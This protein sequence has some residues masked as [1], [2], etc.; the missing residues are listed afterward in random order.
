[1][2]SMYTTVPIQLSGQSYTSR[3][4][5]ISAQRSLNMYPEI[6]QDGIAPIIMHSWMGMQLANT[7]FDSCCVSG[8]YVFLGS[9]YAVAGGQLRK[10]SPDLASY[11][12]VGSVPVSDGNQVSFSDNGEVMLIATGAD[13]YQSDGVTV[14]V[15]ASALFNP[16]KV[17]FLNER[18]YINGD[19]G[20][21]AVSDVLSTN[22]D[23]GN[24]FYGRS[25]PQK[26][27]VHHIFNQIIYLFDENSV[28]PWQP[29]D[30]GAPP[31]A[32]INQGII[33]GVGCTSPYGV[34]SSDRYMYFIGA[35]A[36]VYRVSG[37]SAEEITNPVIAHHF[38][39]MD[40][41]E[42][43]VNYIDM[44]GHKFII[45]NFKANREVWVYCE[46]SS[47]WFEIG[48]ADGEYEPVSPVFYRGQWYAGSSSNG[49]ILR[50]VTDYALTG[51]TPVARERVIATISG[52]DIGKSGAMLEM[53][54]FRISMET[55]TNGGFITERSPKFMLIP[56]FDGGYTWSKPIFLRLG[57]LGDYSI[58]VEYHAMQQFRRAVFKLRITDLFGTFYEEAGS[59]TL[60]S[61][62]IDLREVKY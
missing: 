15:V 20:G 32:R 51:S 46:T 35:D 43:R 12:V 23:A 55:G 42:C 33:E 25:T 36:H 62:S 10:Y 29:T 6:T 16:T 58:P 30:V 41:S 26:T 44:N 40:V 39:G 31:V 13:V 34:A 1:M 59:F 61:A 24:T 17:G 27:I 14:S 7:E 47:A 54:K 11:V 49:S 8:C 48:G 56:S 4:I 3:T 60:F 9:F 38:R 21:V 52:E 50:Y 19:D 18:F 22:F 5:P 28:E 37:F 53:S 57:E 45:F 2:P